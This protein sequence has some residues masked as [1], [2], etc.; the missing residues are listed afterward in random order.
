M[1]KDKFKVLELFCGHGGWSKPFAELG[2]DCTG[3]DL[4]DFSK[5]YLGKFIQ[6]DIFDYE[7]K[8]K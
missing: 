2:Y 8:E 4:A 1:N 6:A 7:P 5:S 3:I